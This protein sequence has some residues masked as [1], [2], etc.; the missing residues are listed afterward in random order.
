MKRL[1]GIIIC[2]RCKTI[3]VSFN[4]A[5]HI[6]KAAMPF[7]RGKEAKFAELFSS[8]VSF[9]FRHRNIVLNS[10]NFRIEPFKELL[11]FKRFV[12]EFQFHARNACAFCRKVNNNFERIL[13]WL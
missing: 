10:L 7:G 12:S 2:A 11:F 13:Q 6:L 1:S 4:R 9:I 8:A 3:F 5:R